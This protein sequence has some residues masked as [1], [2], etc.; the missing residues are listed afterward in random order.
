M[1]GRKLTRYVLVSLASNGMVPQ[2][3]GN[4]TNQST[5]L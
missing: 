3:S 2:S 1:G 4:T 5:D